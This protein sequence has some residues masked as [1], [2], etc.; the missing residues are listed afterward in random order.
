MEKA[1]PAMLEAWRSL[2]RIFA[3]YAPALRQAAAQ[4]GEANDEACRIFTAAQLEANAF[5]NVGG[6]AEIL[7]LH[8]CDMLSDVWKQIRG[9]SVQSPDH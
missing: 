3:K 7:A 8:V 4:D 2:Y 5:Y 1:P 6:D 9:Q